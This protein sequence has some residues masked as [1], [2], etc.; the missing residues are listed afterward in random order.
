[1]PTKSWSSL[2]PASSCWVFFLNNDWPTLFLACTSLA[3]YFDALQPYCFLQLLASL[4]PTTACSQ[5]CLL[6]TRLLS[7]TSLITCCWPLLWIPW[8]PSKCLILV[9]VSASGRCLWVHISGFRSL[10][11][12]AVATCG[13]LIWATATLAISL[14]SPIEICPSLFLSVL[15]Y[16]I[17]YTLCLIS[18]PSPCS[19]LRNSLPFLGLLLSHSRQDIAVWSQDGNRALLL[20]STR[21]DKALTMHIWA[22]RVDW[23]C[24]W[25]RSKVWPIS[26]PSYWGFVCLIFNSPYSVYEICVTV[27]LLAHCAVNTL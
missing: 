27:T 2:S 19:L 9:N 1:M 7:L 21:Q 6:S 20:H 11:L 16:T 23:V 14:S 13:H 24:T 4:I 22:E 3:R 8:P 18:M 10:T 15:F 25:P 26:L 17:H 12:A 5:F